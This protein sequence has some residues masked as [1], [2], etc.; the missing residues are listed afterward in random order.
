[1]VRP[2]GEGALAT[3]TTFETGTAARCGALATFGERDVL[4]SIFEGR[5][6]PPT[7]AC[8]G[9]ARATRR[10]I[11]DGLWALIVTGPRAPEAARVRGRRDRRPS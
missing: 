7:P 10:P 8:V 11:R 2:P 5:P 3:F 1:M 9:E 6:L 4:V